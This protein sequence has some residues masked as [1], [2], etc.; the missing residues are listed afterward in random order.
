[1]KKYNYYE[2]TPKGNNRSLGSSYKPLW[3]NIVG[4]FG[5]IHVR[6]CVWK[7]NRGTTKG[8]SWT[9][10]LHS[11]ETNGQ[12]HGLIDKDVVN[13]WIDGLDEPKVFKI[14]FQNIQGVLETYARPS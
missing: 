1:M 4:R 7:N 11:T 12:T 10:E 5:N 3:W 8:G 14:L 9:N 2:E 6:R 13:I